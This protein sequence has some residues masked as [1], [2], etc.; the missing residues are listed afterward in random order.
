[1]TYTFYDFN[2]GFYTLRVLVDLLVVIHQPE[3][4][5]NKISIGKLLILNITKA[6]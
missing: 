2:V 4:R 5:K 1:M 3:R 6:F